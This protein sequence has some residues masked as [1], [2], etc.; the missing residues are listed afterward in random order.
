VVDDGNLER[1]TIEVASVREFGRELDLDIRRS[2]AQ[3]H[4][5]SRCTPSRPH[6]KILHRK[7]DP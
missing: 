5:T 4:Q 2:W 7:T 3:G 1:G 6:L